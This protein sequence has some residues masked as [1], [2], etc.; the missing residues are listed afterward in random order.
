MHSELERTLD[1]IPENAFHY[2]KC[3]GLW[4]TYDDGLVSGLTTGKAS[5]IWEIRC[6]CALETQ[7]ET[8]RY[9]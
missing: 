1:M 8:Y 7:F 2:V 3:A 6:C 9:C 5:L 4:G